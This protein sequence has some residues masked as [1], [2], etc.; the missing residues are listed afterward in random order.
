VSFR[1]LY[2]CENRKICKQL[3]T[4][5]Y[6]KLFDYLT[7]NRLVVQLKILVDTELFLQNVAVQNL[8]HG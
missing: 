6:A 1:I 8:Q 4:L 3:I 2:A 7:E 5:F